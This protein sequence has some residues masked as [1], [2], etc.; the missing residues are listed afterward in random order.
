MRKQ[1]YLFAFLIIIFGKAFPQSGKLPFEDSTLENTDHGIIMPYN[2]LI[3]SAGTVITFGD[4]RLENHALDLCL[5][6]DKKNIAIEDRY[7]IS[8]LNIKK[9]KLIFA[10]KNELEVIY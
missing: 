8:V 5:M 3:Q 1:I 9:N 6:P 7:G 10:W 4:P 2:R